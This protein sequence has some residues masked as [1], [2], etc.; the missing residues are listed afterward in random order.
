MDNGSKS[1][2]LP[3]TS[4]W[5]RRQANA[6]RNRR[7]R[8]RRVLIT[9]VPLLIAAAAGWGSALA[10]PVRARRPAHRHGAS[11]RHRAH[12]NRTHRKRHHSSSTTHHSRRRHHA[13]P[14]TRKGKPTA[15]AGTNKGQLSPLTGTDPVLFGDQTIESSVGIA[16]AGSVV[17]FPYTSQLTGG[18]RSLT[19]YVDTGNQASGLIAGLYGDKHGRPGS[20]LATGSVSMPAAPA[21]NTVSFS[22]ALVSA[23]KNYWIAL[24]GTGGTLYFRDHSGGPCTGLSSSKSSLTSLPSSWSMQFTGSQLNS[25][26]AS[27]YASGLE[28][29]PWNTSTPTI[30]GQ[31]MQGQTLSASTGSWGNDPTSYA[32]QWQDCT[33]SGCSNIG[34]A[35]GSSYALQSSDVGDTA[36]VVVTASNASGSATATSPPTATVA[37]PTPA[38]PVNTLPP[39]ISGTAAQG[40]TLSASTGTWANSPTS[41]A[42]QW[43]DCTSSGCT[44]IS[45]ATGSSYVLQASDVGDTIDVVVM[46]SNSGGSSPATSLQTA[47]VAAAPLSPPSNTSPPAISGTPTQG[48]TLTT[49]TGTWTNSPTSYAYQWQRCV[50]TGCTSIGGATNSSY[51]LQSSDVGASIE[52]SV[53]ASNAGGSASATSVQ[54]ATVAPLPPSNTALPA[55]SGTPTQGNALTASTGTWTNSPT[56]YAYQWQRCTSSGC[57]NISGATSGSYTLQS[58]D[59]GDTI[60]AIVTASNSGGSGSATSAKTA[61]VAA[62]TSSPPSNTSLPTISGTPTQG[63]T[64]SASNG[65]WSNSPTSYTYQWQLCITSCINISGATNSTYVLASSDVGDTIDVVVTASNSGGSG[66]ATSAKTGAVT[67]ASSFSSI[68]ISQPLGT[69]NQPYYSTFQS[70]NS[71]IVYTSDGIFLSYF[72]N[73]GGNSND[74]GDDIVVRSTD[75]GATWTRLIDIPNIKSKHAPASLETDSSGNIYAFM[76]SQA[77][78]SDDARAYMFPK[79]ANFANN[80]TDYLELSSAGVGDNKFATAYDPNVNKLFFAAQYYMSTITATCQSEIGSSGTAACSGGTA[81]ASQ[82]FQWNHFCNYSSCQSGSSG[83]ELSYPHLYMGRDAT[84]AHV[85]LLSWTEAPTPETNAQYYDIRFIFSTDDGATWHGANGST[86]CGSGCG[87]GWPL[88]TTQNGPSFLVNPSSET[89]STDGPWLDTAYVQD[90]YFM[91]MYALH[92][93]YYLSPADKVEYARFSWSG[94]SATLSERILYPTCIST[95]SLCPTQGSEGAFFSGNGTSNAPIYYLG[96]EYSG[97]SDEVVV[98]KSTDSGATWQD[99]LHSSGVGNWNPYA[100]SG[101]FRLGPGGEVLGVMMDASNGLTQS[102]NTIDFFHAQ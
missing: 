54:T 4:R 83:Q 68:A 96:Q 9:V 22:S 99:S 32:Y 30:S 82:T 64:L 66:S 93:R 95:G 41:Y 24:L 97:S 77:W 52:V 65:S 34:G 29:A 47:A 79:S 91:F 63:N 21:W 8:V 89:S 86:I 60:D 20:L 84:D 70:Q 28:V 48:N 15:P 81:D 14:H 12:S 51:K 5:G 11:L 71:R 35:T 56:S 61:T 74:V 58:S 13:G 1:S 18:V 85:L 25:C 94:G 98:L 92:P 10:H 45:G 46:A 49:S 43:Q 72:T 23:G 53:T 19:V 69:S 73:W 80:G 59:I 101:G 88:D 38:A 6:P 90:G 31:P 67:S 50:T 7:Y 75:N 87:Y 62:S 37:S 78:G 57:S 16:Q 39:T 2:G 76:E 55:I 26:P 102:S 100:E 27:A 33:S 42:Y 17:A 3:V 40:Q 44:N 36:D